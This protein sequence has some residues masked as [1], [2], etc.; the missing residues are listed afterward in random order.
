MK[1]MRIEACFDSH[2]H[3]QATGEFVGRLRLDSIKKSEDLHSLK[4]EASHQRGDWILGFGW[5]ESKWDFAPSRHL[6]DRMF[7]NQPVAFTRCD[8]HALWVNSEALR[9]ASLLNSHASEIQ[10]GR[11]DR[12]SSIERLPTGVLVDRAMEVVQRWIPP[13]EAREIRRDLLAG[14]K[15]FNTQGFTHIRDMTCSAAQWNEAIKLDEAG[16]LTLA[17][18]EYFWLRSIQEFDDVLNLAI[19]ALKSQTQNL[20]VKGLKVFLD[21][22]LGSEGAWLSKCYHG[23]ESR[24]L[25]LWNKTD[26]RQALV[27][28]WNVNLAVALHAIG[29]ETVDWL[30]TVA[31]ELKTEGHFGKIHIEHAELVRPE[32]IEKMRSLDIA[33]HMQPSHWLSD[34][35]WLEGKVGD[36]ARQAFPWRR[37]E[38]AG[39]E[40]DFGSDAPIASPSVA[41]TLEALE[42]SALKGIPALIHSPIRYLGHKDLDW[43]PNSY[44]EFKLNAPTRVVFRG[45]ELI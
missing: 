44:T 1:V 12:E 19:R 5:D 38:E 45:Q 17:V 42:Q 7:P 2:V 26:L 28:C 31:Q 40:L 15:I 18:E 16:L 6:L 39:I 9:R 3:W 21:G 4:V 8:G 43:A 14:A 24:G 11:I 36:L 37:L 29:D 32:T 25:R 30:V 22:A 10:G 33:C 27:A 41:R 20:R 13:L 35:Q 23:T 34:H